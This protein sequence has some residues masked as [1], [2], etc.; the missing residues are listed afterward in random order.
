MFKPGKPPVIPEVAWWKVG[1]EALSTTEWPSGTMIDVHNI[2][3]LGGYQYSDDNFNQTWG[4]T[5]A[6][7]HEQYEDWNNPDGKIW[8]SVAFEKQENDILKT[9]RAIYTLDPKTKKREIIGEWNYHDAN[10]TQC[11]GL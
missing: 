4:V 10:L 3:N 5:H 9:K 8:S 1:K 6:P 2:K 11:K 7:S